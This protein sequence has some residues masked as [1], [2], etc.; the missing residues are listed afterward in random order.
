MLSAARR[1]LRDN[2]AGVEPAT[3]PSSSSFAPLDSDGSQHNTT[4]TATSP[5]QSQTTPQSSDNYHAQV[6]V[7][8]DETESAMGIARKISRLGARGIDSC[9]TFA[10]PDGGYRIQS[11]QEDIGSRRVPISSILGSRFP[12]RVLINSLLEDYFDAVHWFS[13]V[14]SEQK[15]RQQLAAVEDGYAYQSDT[16][17]LTLLSM[18]LCMA[19]WYRSHRNAHEGDDEWRRWNEDLL[20]IVE[21][22]LI[23][24]MDEK[25]IT[26]VQTCILLGSHHVYHGRPNLSFALLGATIKIAYALGMHLHLPHKYPDEFE[27]RKRVWW[28]IYTWDRFASIS[29]GRPMSINDEDFNVEM[30]AEYSEFPH[31]A[32]PSTSRQLP[33]IVYSRYQT[34]LS[35]LY[36]IASPALRFIFGCLSTPKA[37][38]RYESDYASLASD[39][40]GRLIAW[41]KNLPPQLSLDLD[42][43]FSPRNSD[44]GTRANTLQSFSLQLTFDNL[45]IVLYRP[46]L[47]RQVDHLSISSSGTFTG[48]TPAASSTRSA[49]ASNPY[50]HDIASGLSG[51]TSNPEYCLSAAARVARIT[52]LPELVQLAKE[53]HLVA[54]MAINLFHAAIVLILLALAEPLSDKAQKLKRTITRMLRLQQMLGKQSTLSKQSGFVLQN[55]TS[56]LFMREEEAMV[57]QPT[58]PFKQ[59]GPDGMRQSQ[60][61]TNRTLSEA[62]DALRVPSFSFGGVN[63]NSQGSAETQVWPNIAVAQRLNESLASVQQGELSIHYSIVGTKLMPFLFP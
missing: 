2:S 59:A 14:I 23:C 20:R 44:W 49:D 6:N 50:Q 3:T 34:E 51:S 33:G 17:F 48:A 42:Q 62:E 25:S 29:Y 24:L 35:S 18:V 45:L 40:A 57:G 21:S 26:A 53:S 56:L 47:A 46:F 11:P 1:R 30:P 27:E 58:P 36:R 63:T 19:A 12:D 41:R 37:K 22:R 8:Q 9:S 61:E 54:F 43:D 4:Q 55:L 13:L 28:T 16:P 60:D 39:V 31:F 32:Q 52:E 5:N 15:F 7:D 38:E 10:I